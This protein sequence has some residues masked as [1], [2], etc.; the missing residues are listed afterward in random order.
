MLHDSYRVIIVGVGV[1]RS[2]FLVGRRLYTWILG[3]G[4]LARGTWHSGSYACIRS[5]TLHGIEME[6]TMCS[7][8][9]L[10]LATFADQASSAGEPG[11]MVSGSGFRVIR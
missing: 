11:S 5:Q 3:L 4:V 10:A 9:A 1:T 6:L 7:R 8:G 2:L